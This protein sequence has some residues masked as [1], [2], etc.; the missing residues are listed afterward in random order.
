ME[1][2]SIWVEKNGYEYGCHRMPGGAIRCGACGHGSV[3]A[4][5]CDRCGAELCHTIAGHPVDALSV[6]SEDSKSK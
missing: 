2:A 1:S 3:K 4:G 5:K 6:S